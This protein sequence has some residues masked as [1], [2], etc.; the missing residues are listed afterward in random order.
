MQ[1]IIGANTR[2]VRTDHT[3]PMPLVHETIEGVPRETSRRTPASRYAPRPTRTIGPGTLPQRDAN[4][5]DHTMVATIA[6]STIAITKR[7]Y[8]SCPILSP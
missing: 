1:S 5:A 2:L 7:A 4:C 3:M 8:S 6:Q